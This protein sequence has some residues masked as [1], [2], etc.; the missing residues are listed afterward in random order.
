MGGTPGITDPPVA[1]A[2]GQR[3]RRLLK[4]V[5]GLDCEGGCSYC[6]L[7]KAKG[8][9]RERRIRLD[10][11]LAEPKIRE[12]AERYEISG[13]E[14]GAGETF[15]QPE[16]WEWLLALNARELN[17]PVMAFTGGLSK[18]T[19]RTLDAIAAST[20]PVLLL[21]SYDGRRSERNGANWREVEAAFRT[22]KERLA[23][24]PRVTLKL[25]ACV[26][27]RDARH[28]REN[29]R[30]L[31]DLDPAPF[32][33]RPLKRAFNEV[34]REEFVSQLAAFLDEASEKGV[35]LLRAPEEGAWRLGMKRDWTCHRLGVSLLPD[36][37]FTDC[38]VAWYCSDFPTWRTLPSLTGL[39]R[40]FAG[41][42]APAPAAC[43]RCL[44]VFDLCNLCPAGLADFRRST[45]ESFYDDGFCRM[46]NRASLLLLG[47]ALEERPGLEVAV[48]RGAVDSR[49]RLEGKRLVLSGP[50]GKPPLF[51]DPRDG[52]TILQVA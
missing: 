18:R 15:D 34:E 16:L 5:F 26:T 11:A 2:A 30:S 4:V 20:A 43:A 7:K 10:P 52:H 3:P 12:V 8:L 6:A 32:A 35:R 25:T 33:F 42:E 28:L 36:G 51:V 39:D 44:D 40:F 29:F 41:L 49:L 37:R 13:L 23:G 21:F 48:R 22:M 17:V 38:Y 9:P 47:K 46:V 19:A 50:G 31:L 45:G 24:A 14:V 1:L 27:P